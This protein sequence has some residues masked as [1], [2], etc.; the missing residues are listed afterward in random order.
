[1][2]LTALVVVNLRVVSLVEGVAFSSSTY[3]FSLL[4]NQQEVETVGTVF[5]SSGSDLYGVTYTLKTY[6]ELFSINASG[7]IQ[8]RAALNREEQEWYILKVE[9]GDTRTPP[10]SAV[11]VV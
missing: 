8:T 5:A 1:M 10:T 7:A 3:N 6:T 11:A 2:S 9:A 4:E